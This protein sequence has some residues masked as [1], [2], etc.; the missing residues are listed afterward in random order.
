M[1]AVPPRSIAMLPHRLLP[2]VALLLPLLCASLCAPDPCEGLEGPFSAVLGTGVSS[3][4]PLTDG[5]VVAFTRGIQGGTHVDGAVEVEHISFPTD[6]VA[7]V[8]LLPTVSFTLRND[9]D[10]LVGGYQDLPRPFVATDDT[11]QTGRRVGEQVQFFE[12]GSTLVG[13]TLRL[14][15]EVK[16]ICGHTVADAHT[17]VIA[18]DGSGGGFGSTN[19]GGG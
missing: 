8:A 5:D 1:T 4:A 15:V 2:V 14:S 16:D 7:D 11:G 13:Q 18:D 3:L 17:I 9:Q 10:T 12:D 6:P 19:G